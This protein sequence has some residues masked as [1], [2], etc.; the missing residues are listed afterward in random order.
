[1]TE[2][3]RPNILVIDDSSDMLELMNHYLTKGEIGEYQLFSN[4]YHALNYLVK[5]KVDLVIIDVFLDS[6]TGFQVGKILRNLLQ[7]NVPI[8]YISSHNNCLKEFYQ[9][10]QRNSYFM[11]KPFD[12]NTFLGVV[13]NM[14]DQKAA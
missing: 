3:K 11:N 9:Q 13:K 1:M 10:D 12:Q 14:M 7:V 5:E 6:I 2:N 8:I 4:E